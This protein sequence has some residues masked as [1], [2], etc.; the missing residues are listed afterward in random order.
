MTTPAA[1]PQPI[2]VHLASVAAELGLTAAA[3]SPSSP[4]SP[5]SSSTRSVYRTINLTSLDPVQEIMAA[6]D[7]RI[8]AWLVAVDADIFIS[9]NKSDAGAG[10]GSYIPC[11]TPT[12]TKP[13]LASPYPVQDNRVIYAGPVA[14]IA[15]GAVLRV[16]VTAV[17]R[18]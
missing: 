17:Y 18:D 12:A 9:D 10:R 4:S 7:E 16:S 3:S 1:E 6:S 11:V 2:P 5:S 14:A 15:G 8:I 13:N